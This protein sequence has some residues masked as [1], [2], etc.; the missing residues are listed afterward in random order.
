MISVSIRI[1]I[2]LFIFFVCQ[3]APSTL[4]ALAQE[5]VGKA[6]IEDGRKLYQRGEFPEAYSK[7]KSSLSLLDKPGDKA[8]A[9]LLLGAVHMAM[10]NGELAQQEFITTVRLDPELKL[11]P[12]D[13]QPA[14]IKRY[15]Q[16][17]AAILGAIIVQT[18]PSGAH[19]YIDNEYK[20]LSPATMDNIQS[21][22][23]TIKVVK[24][25][26]HIEQ[27][28]ITVN[29]L[30]RTELLLEL[31]VIDPDV[32]A[33]T[34]NIY[35]EPIDSDIP[36]PDDAPPNIFHTPVIASSDASKLVIKTKIIDNQ[37]L[38]SAT[39]FYRRAIEQNYLRQE[40]ETDEPEDSYIAAVPEI[41]MTAK[42]IHYYIAAEDET[43]NIQYSGT[44]EYP[45]VV[46]IFKVI[47][48]RDGYVV[49]RK[50]EGRKLAKTV[51]V[52]VG[53]MKGYEKDQALYIFTDDD[54]VIDPETGMV[55]RINQK[56]LGKIK[57]TIV[58]ATSSQAK[59]VKE[60]SKGAITTG[61]LIRARPSAPKNVK[62]SFEKSGQINVSW[63]ENPEPE[64]NGYIVY[65]SDNQ[66]GPFVE[67]G[68]TRGRDHT[69]FKD[70]RSRRNIIDDNSNYYYMISAINDEKEKSDLSKSALVVA[71]GG[72]EPPENM[73]VTSGMIRQ[74]HLGWQPSGD[75]EAAGYKIMRSD[76]KNGEYTE[77]AVIE[78][79]EG[80][81]FVDKPDNETGH[82]LEDGKL[83]WYKMLSFNK[84]GA[85]GKATEPLEGFSRQKP[86]TPANFHVSDSSA[87]TVTLAWE[88]SVDQE[89]TGYRIYKNS[90][91]TGDF[92]LLKVI[93][94]NSAT[95]YIDQFSR[96]DN[97][98]D[99]TSYF[100]RITAVN[101]G[102]VESKLSDTVRGVAFAPP[103]AP[104]NV[105]A[106]SA[107][108]KQ[109]T[110][111]WDL[112]TG[113]KVTG[114]TIYRGESANDMKLLKK[115]NDSSITQYHDKGGWSA[116]LKD[117]ADYYY[118]VKSVNSAQ[119]E[120]VENEQVMATTKKV[121]S[122]PQG[123]TFSATETSITLKWDQNPEPDISHYNIYSDGFFGKR[124][125]GTTE[126][127][128]Y[129][130]GNLSPGTE[131]T[132]AVKAVGQSGLISG[133]SAMVKTRT[134]K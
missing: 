16:A 69:E 105:I 38:R 62:G 61:A 7:L 94:D 79:T 56:L 19:V 122:P 9:H 27:R 89:I 106:I 48:R 50:G 42:E 86:A 30:E 121:P 130:I 2:W 100:Y 22:A 76:L 126:N 66:S 14:V 87:R 103:L 98:K 60:T 115:I 118:T 8:Q 53:S 119:I 70:R 108:V 125:I 59:I 109:V 6:L 57:I 101:N 113:S 107:L 28:D 67:A 68:K 51:T 104:K 49:E 45:H 72:P 81:A 71:R 4:P 102:G 92:I 99:G 91:P 120:S 40:M 13:Y 82:Q 31:N 39:L 116:R 83:Y 15:N 32:V 110:L 34:N 20:G 134:L 131:Y 65:R 90:K 25:N 21:G 73:N 41:F 128:S 36:S 132:Y 111:S 54:K 24:K 47:S 77:L 84:A 127:S 44:S 123:L 85:N 1:S 11:A 18:A 129:A 80:D 64:V 37:N 74:I 29:P 93:A 43:G 78:S 75:K 96:R 88:K 97:K 117:G 3:L 10:G 52:N 124:K 95:E 23:H 33:T 58:G 112:A 133:Y 46:K 35:T 114:Y 12:K 63:D 17:K 55:L 26:Y 5:Q